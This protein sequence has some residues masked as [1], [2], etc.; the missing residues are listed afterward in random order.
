MFSHSHTRLD[1]DLRATMKEK[2]VQMMSWE[3][4]DLPRHVNYLPV[5]HQSN[6][7]PSAFCVKRLEA[8]GDLV[9]FH[10]LEQQRVERIIRC[11]QAPDLHA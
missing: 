8:V 4:F 3:Y 7:F 9:G 10:A 5:D 1:A 6:Y 2:A 11:A